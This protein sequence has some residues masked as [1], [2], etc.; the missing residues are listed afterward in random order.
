[1]LALQT[2]A[3]ILFFR[4]VIPRPTD[5]LLTALYFIINTK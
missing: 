3:G 1:L 2:A 4:R 5:P